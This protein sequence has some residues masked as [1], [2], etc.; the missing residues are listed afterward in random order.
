MGKDCS[1][2]CGREATHHVTLSDKTRRVEFDTC[3]P[4]G[5]LMGDE[6]V[7]ARTGRPQEDRLERKG[8]DLAKIAQYRGAIR[9]TTLQYRSQR[10]R[11]QNIGRW[12]EKNVSD[13]R[14]L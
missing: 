12:T 1:F 13:G 2:E 9:D 14:E 5:E 8:G 10:L 11:E 4:H 7:A 6:R 3:Y